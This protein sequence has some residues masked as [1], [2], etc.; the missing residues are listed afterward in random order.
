MN[1]QS[2]TATLAS[3]FIAIAASSVDAQVKRNGVW[4][5]GDAQRGNPHGLSQEVLHRSPQA[6]AELPNP[7]RAVF[8]DPSWP[9]GVIPYAF[10]AN[11]SDAQK[12]AMLGAMG[13]LA[14]TADVTFIERS[15]EADFIRIRDANGNSSFVGRIG[16][17]QEVRIFNWNF[18]YIMVHEL[19]HALGFFH[20]QSAV[21]RD[22]FVTILVD[23]IQ[24][25][26]LNNF[27]IQ[28][29]ANVTSTYDY[30]SVMHYGPFDFSIMPGLLF[31]ILT[32]DPAAQSAIGQREFLST[33]DEEGLVT[34]LGPWFPTTWLDTSPLPGQS[35]LGTLRD[36]ATDLE[37]ALL[38][39]NSFGI[40]GQDNRIVNVQ[41]GTDTVSASPGSP[42]VINQLVRIEGA[43]LTIE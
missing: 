20:E 16:G 31:T 35:S 27:A 33:G 8:L 12:I 30:S 39:A 36:P 26:A 2:V 43:R 19:M 11:V 42:L 9:D 40:F 32:T 7:Q 28:P 21:D 4:Q 22:Q 15:T 1:K 25:N 14:I 6:C 13:T 17:A 3:A 38:I 10:D 23:N 37:Q 41:E 24:P 18:R 5:G 34:M 29:N